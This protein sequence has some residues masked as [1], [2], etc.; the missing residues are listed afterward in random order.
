MP[1]NYTLG[2]ILNSALDNEI[3]RPGDKVQRYLHYNEDIGDVVAHPT[4]PNLI[5]VVF[6]AGYEA[7]YILTNTGYW[8]DCEAKYVRKVDAALVAWQQLD[9]DLRFILCEARKTKKIS[10][11]K[12]LRTVTGLGLV[13]A[14]RAIETFEP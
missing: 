10:A 3:I 12:Y 9:Y 11:I 6:S 2:D 14:K 8:L 5:I 13:D 4:N 1:D 7:S